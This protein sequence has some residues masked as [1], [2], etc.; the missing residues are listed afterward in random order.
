M[1]RQ[2][3]TIIAL[4]ALLACGLVSAGYVLLKERL[5]NPL[6][7]TYDIHAELQAADG[8][9]P[10]LGQP[11]NVAGVAIGEVTGARLTSGL[12]DITMTINRSQLAHVY[13]NASAALDPI[14]P[15]DD[16]E[17]NLVPGH[18]PAPRLPA[19]ATL[20]VGQTTSPVQ[21]E[22]LLSNLN[23]DTR[24]WLGSLLTSLGQGTAG[25]AGN[26]RSALATL[27]PSTTQL[28]QITAALATRRRSLAALVH[29][30]AL[31]SR[32][33]S[34]D[35][36]LPHVVLAGDET[37]HALASQDRALRQTVSLLPGALQKTDATLTHLQAFSQRLGPT[38]TSLLPALNRL[39]AALTTLEP[40]ATT[41][42]VALA[43]NVRPLVVHATPLLRELAPAS[44]D[45]STVTP[46]LTD[47]LQAAN[48][49]VN[50]L[51]YNPG[52]KN[53]G[54]LYWADWFFHNWNSLAS[55]GDANGPVARANVLVNCS[56]LANMVQLGTLLESVIGASGVC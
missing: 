54:Y 42:D 52:G 26:I 47:A 15:L 23:G 12:A 45:L 39:P 29:N 41:A 50:E 43:R 46:D 36:E 40:F 22:D 24:D 6:A 48:Y 49:F 20:P 38:L 28:R 55:S 16:V 56:S 37:L 27:G 2:L 5:P 51:A 21:L 25:Q 8:I 3:P 19:G 11:V 7:S 1:R 30:V 9:V 4:I 53:Q 35:G 13:G 34:Q 14:T 31:V 10:G 17:I 33:A 18:P 44:R 32:A